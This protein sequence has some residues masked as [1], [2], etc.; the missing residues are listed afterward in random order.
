MARA[1]YA[2]PALERTRAAPPPSPLPL[3]V[4]D[5]RSGRLV[6]LTPMP[7]GVLAALGAHFAPPD[8]AAVVDSTAGV[9]DFL[10]PAISDD[11]ARAFQK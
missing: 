1:F 5:P 4:W 3:Q 2:T 7:P 6:T 9:L 11:L 10:G 8:G